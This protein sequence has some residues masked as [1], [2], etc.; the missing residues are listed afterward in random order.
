MLVRCC[1]GVQPLRLR[2]M[3]LG[4]FRR[5]DELFEHALIVA[6]GPATDDGLHVGV[7]AYQRSEVVTDEHCP[8]VSRMDFGCIESGC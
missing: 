2:E 8:T 4:H 1:P 6:S 7:A 3:F 5:M